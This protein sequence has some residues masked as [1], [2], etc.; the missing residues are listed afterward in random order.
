MHFEP[1]SVCIC[2]YCEYAFCI[3]VILSFIQYKQKTDYKAPLPRD[4]QMHFEPDS[5]YFVYI[6]YLVI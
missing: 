3:C 2:E 1:K 5:V 4:P 6:T